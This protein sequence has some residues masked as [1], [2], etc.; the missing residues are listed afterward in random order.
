VTYSYTGND[1][2]GGADYAHTTCIDDPGI[3]TSSPCGTT[4]VAYVN[5][6]A[7]TVATFSFAQSSAQM[8]LGLRVTISSLGLPK[9]TAKILD[10]KL[11]AALDA[12][13]SGRTSSACKALAHVISTAT[14]EAGKK[15]E[16]AD[17]ADIVAKAS[18]IQTALGC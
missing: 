6:V 15:I 1:V 9:G 8:L 14:T 2:A 4:V 12:V 5:F 18:A 7:G 10:E 13:A 3:P 16:S 11:L 17:A